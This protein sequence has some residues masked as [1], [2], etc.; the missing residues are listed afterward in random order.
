MTRRS[1]SYLTG[2]VPFGVVLLA[3]LS[4]LGAPAEAPVPDSAAARGRVTLRLLG[5]NDFHG[6][7]EPPRRGLGGAAWLKAHLDAAAVPGRTIRVHAGDMV[8]ALP[9]ISAH[10]RD[11]PTVEV[12]N[13]LGFDVGT[14][15]N[16]E[17][18]A[19]GRELMRLLRGGD[20]FE[21][22]R[23]PVIA[24]NTFGRDGRL[25]LPPIAVVERAGVRVGFIGV[26][27]PATPR[28]LLPRHAASFRFGDISESVNRW[29][30]LLARRGV[31]AIVVLAHEGARSQT[32]LNGR[33][34]DGPV[35]EEA[36]QMDDEVDL[37]VAATATRG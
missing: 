7:L 2:A 26:T 28:W 33:E 12:A 3:A 35:L 18:D 34:P 17:F 32:G 4:G 15:G 36:A 24:A 14:L 27:T 13:R 25:L 9:L 22:T 11:Q 16:H 5:V 1:A 29:V 31:R 21:G 6:H 20:G 23:F 19:G 30:P 10:F 37:V 8:G